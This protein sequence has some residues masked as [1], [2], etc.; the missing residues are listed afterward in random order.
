MAAFSEDSTFLITD[1]FAHT[2]KEVLSKNFACR[3][4]ACSRR[5]PQKELYIF[6]SDVPGPIENKPGDRA[7]RWGRQFQ[8]S[9]A[10]PGAAAV[11]RAAPSGSRIHPISPRPTTAAALIEIEPGGMPEMHWHPNGDEWQYYSPGAAA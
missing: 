10:R 1:W 11:P 4:K 8:P 2:P 6:K 9:Y 7:E 3:R 5:T